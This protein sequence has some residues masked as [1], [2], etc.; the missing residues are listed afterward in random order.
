MKSYYITKYGRELFDY[1]C[2]NKNRQWICIK[3]FKSLPL[4]L[5]NALF[6]A[7]TKHGD[8][9]LSLIPMLMLFRN[10]K[11][12]TLND[13]NIKQLT[14]ESFDYISA[15]MRYIKYNYKNKT[16]QIGIYLEKIVFQSNP[17]LDGK[18]NSTLRKL[19]DKYYTI[20]EE[21]DWI[22]EYKFELESTHN[23]VFVNNQKIINQKIIHYRDH[24]EEP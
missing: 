10:L 2:S 21:R 1:F 13:I 5:K 24:E 6:I 3:N 9:R 14:E 15:V 16:K 19:A 23:L 11:E 18:E 12:I 17:Q 22:I 7:E 20:F 8:E 4:P